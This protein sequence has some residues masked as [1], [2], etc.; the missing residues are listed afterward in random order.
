MSEDLKGC[1][2]ILSRGVEDLD[3][4]EELKLRLQEIETR[5]ARHF[6]RKRIGSASRK[7]MVV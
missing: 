7:S 6:L 1:F 3:V 4:R 5:A 2:D